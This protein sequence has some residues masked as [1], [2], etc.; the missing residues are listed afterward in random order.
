MLGMKSLLILAAHRSGVRGFM[1]VSDE[2]GL[3]KCDM[4]AL[5]IMRARWLVGPAVRPGAF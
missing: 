4:M 2:F 1:R 5:D 3:L